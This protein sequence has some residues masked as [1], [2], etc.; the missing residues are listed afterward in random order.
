MS[1]NDL[2][3]SHVDS[4]SPPRLLPPKRQGLGPDPPRQPSSWAVRRPVR[5]A[6]TKKPSFGR[7]SLDEREKEKRRI[8]AEQNID[9][10]VFLERAFKLGEGRNSEVYLGAY[11][12]RMASP[13]TD[14]IPWELCAIKRLQ[15]D[16][17]SQL[18]GLE[19][20]FALRRLGHHPHI[21]RLLG[22]LDEVEFR[23]QYALEDVQAHEDPPHLLIV[24][25]YLPF[26]LASFV[27]RQ[28]TAVTLPQWL[29][30]ALQLTSTIEWLHQRG[31]VH[32][33][34]KQENVLLTPH[35]T[36]K[37]CDFS[38]VL[39]SNASSPATDTYSVGTPAFRAPE[40][41]N[42]TSWSPSEEAGLAHP[43]L[44]YT[45]D[46]FSLGVL[47]YTLATG[48]EPN[49]RA[50]SIMAMRQRQ[51]IFFSS[52][53]GDRIER[54]HMG[55]DAQ[56]FTTSPVSSMTSSP[57]RESRSS[58]MH[59]TDALPSY[60]VD[61]LL[62]PSPFPKGIL[63]ARTPR[64][65]AW[66][67]TTSAVPPSP[68]RVPLMRAASIHTAGKADVTAKAHGTS[69]SNSPSGGLRRAR[70]V[71]QP[72]QRAKTDGLTP[73]RDAPAS[74]TPIHSLPM[75]ELQDALPN[76]SAS[77]SLDE[78]P[79]ADGAPALIMPGGDRLPD[80]LRDLIQCMVEPQPEARPTTKRIIETLQKHIDFLFDAYPAHIPSASSPM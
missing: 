53:E 9:I 70:T 25:E 11:A 49:H 75:Q 45:L 29:A 74:R 71:Q 26:S 27:R 21:V 39:F 13:A 32:G 14:S 42:T 12:P 4:P 8:R 15:V 52:E 46:I 64:D 10:R 33:D 57:S 5:P 31:C 40:L 51:N 37:L 56:S 78:R 66:S 20:A 68:Q 36:V 19:E 73:S 35:L 76:L 1:K 67:G 55:C 43:A 16:R 18:A 77:T 59:E 34:I 30:W 22:V 61:R 38:S 6:H 23:A 58:S 54:I 24:L 28:P 2:F 3:Y 50:N 44:S 7:M 17:E 63:T 65:R 47:L 41:F 69:S 48:V 80:E 60:I 79:Y 62:D 72:G